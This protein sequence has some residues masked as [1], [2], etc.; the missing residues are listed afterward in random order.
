MTKFEELHSSL[1]PLKQLANQMYPHIHT[2]PRCT[3]VV[4]SS[5]QPEKVAIIVASFRSTQYK[6]FINVQVH[7]ANIDVVVVALMNYKISREMDENLKVL[8]RA[9]TKTK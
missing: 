3:G 5:Q 6:S 1:A 4:S 7:I 8:E 2:F 9:F